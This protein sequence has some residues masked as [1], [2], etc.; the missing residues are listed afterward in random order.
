MISGGEGPVCLLGFKGASTSRSSCAPWPVESGTFCYLYHFF[1]EVNSGPSTPKMPKSV[2]FLVLG[3]PWLGSLCQNGTPKYRPLDPPVCILHNHIL[4][5]TT[6]KRESQHPYTTLTP[7]HCAPTEPSRNIPTPSQSKPSW[8]VPEYGAFH[9]HPTPH[10]SLRLP[11]SGSAGSRRSRFIQQSA[12]R[13][14]PAQHARPSHANGRLGADSPNNRNAT[15]APRGGR[16]TFILD[17]VY[18][19]S[20]HCLTLPNHLIRKLKPY[21]IDFYGTTNQI[22]SKER[23]LFRIM[24]LM[25]LEWLT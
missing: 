7:S 12:V 18:I 15:V 5:Y 4:Q 14:G 13:S 22:L 3:V 24:T 21:Y 25:A 11:F 20:L 9:Y 16:E 8:P 6:Q 19:Y 1:S 2:E 10:F 23:K 17:R